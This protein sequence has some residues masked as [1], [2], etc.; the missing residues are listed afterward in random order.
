MASI[1][2]VDA[3]PAARNEVAHELRGQGHE[4]FE[5]DKAG[6][7]LQAV[8]ERRP[9]LLVLEWTLPDMGGLDVL[10]DVKRRRRDAV[11]VLMTSARNEATDV[12][13]ALDS[14]ADDF[15]G[16][17]YSMP[18]VVARVS[19]CL[20][21]PPT[22]HSSDELR[23]EGITIDRVGHRV[24]VQGEPLTLAPREYRLLVF[25]IANHGRVFSRAQLLL[26]VWGRRAAVGARTVDVHIRRLR[27]LLEPYGYDR[28]LQTARGAGYRFSTD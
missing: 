19:A 25:L 3:D 12:A 5:S 28:F 11:R 6:A 18:E 9:D 22:A 24:Y 16:K 10:T 15:V 1:L 8:E 23:A 27:S 13:T 2:V 7:A 4:V 14:G 26:N 21:R 17:P 20:R